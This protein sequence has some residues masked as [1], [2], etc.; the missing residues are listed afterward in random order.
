MELTKQRAWSPLRPTIMHFRSH[1]GQEVDLVLEANAG[2]I[3]GIEVKASANVEPRDASGLRALAELA[4]PKFVRGIVLY[5]GKHLLPLAENIWRGRF[6]SCGLSE[7]RG[8]RR[9]EER[10]RCD[11][12]TA[13]T[14]RPR[15]P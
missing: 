10:S 1:A 11:T 6:R 12:P 14:R 3:V 2:Q 8:Q 15:R 7:G 9:S 4:G 5:N 13:A